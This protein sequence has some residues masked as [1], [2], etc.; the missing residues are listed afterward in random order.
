MN[1]I[2]IM[3]NNDSQSINLDLSEDMQSKLQ[4]F[5][6]SSNFVLLNTEFVF[7]LSY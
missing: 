6:T 1:E 2:S 7:L 3:Q 5:L 4:S